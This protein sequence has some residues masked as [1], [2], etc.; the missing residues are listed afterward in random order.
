MLKVTGYKNMKI[1]IASGKGGTGKTTV[2][3]NL[4]YYLAKV[5][6]KRVSLIDCD[7]EEPNSHL[8]LSPNWNKTQKISLPIPVIDQ[9]KCTNCGK[10]TD[11]CNYGA[12]ANIKG[13]ILT[14]PAL[15][16]SCGG[17]VHVCPTG[18]ISEVGKEIGE[19]NMGISQNIDLINGKLK[20]GEVLAPPLIKQTKNNATKNDYIILDSPPGTSCPVIEAVSDCQFVILVTEP[21]PFGLN[22]LKLAVDMV[23]ALN[24]PFGVVINRSTMG[25]DSV[26]EYCLNENVP[27]L[28]EIPHDRN[29]A[30][31]YSNGILLLKALPKYEESFSLLIDRLEGMLRD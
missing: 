31:A 1:A 7:V 21:T 23:R 11:L 10:C 8:F 19:L 16:H 30:E 26:K 17:C 24:M 22:D 13:K 6:N 29:I 20:I 18:A 27:I 4:A 5:N 3:T 15:C 28:L 2:A 14:F 12:L 25:N 9:T